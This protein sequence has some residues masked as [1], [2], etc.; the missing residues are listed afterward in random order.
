M[1]ASVG[2]NGG[3]NALMRTSNVKMGLEASLKCKMK[4]DDM[5]KRCEI[6]D[7]IKIVKEVRL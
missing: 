5:S 7:I 2:S 3:K 1:C 6:V 4:N